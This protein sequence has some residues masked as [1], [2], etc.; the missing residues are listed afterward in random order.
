VVLSFDV[1]GS[2]IFSLLL[3]ASSHSTPHYDGEDEQQLEQD[4]AHIGM[5]T[6]REQDVLYCLVAPAAGKTAKRVWVRLVAL[7]LN[8]LFFNHF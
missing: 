7:G 1:T 6:R 4:V 5:G 3:P 2:A 8:F